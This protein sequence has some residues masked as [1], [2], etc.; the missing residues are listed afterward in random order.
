ANRLGDPIAS[1]ATRPKIIRRYSGPLHITIALFG[2]GLFAV[3]SAI[4]LC[5]QA[6]TPT[7]T[8]DDIRSLAALPFCSALAFLL[9]LTY[10]SDITYQKTSLTVCERG[11]LGYNES[12]RDVTAIPWDTIE[13]VWCE[14][15]RDYSSDAGANRRRFGW[16]YTFQC[17]DGQRFTFAGHEGAFA[18][19]YVVDR[20]INARLLPDAIAAYDAGRTVSFGAIQVSQEGLQV[21]HKAVPWQ[22]IL[23]VEMEGEQ[24]IARLPDWQHW[25]G[26]SKA[27]TPNV[28][29]LKALIQ[30]ISAGE[31]KQVGIDAHATPVFSHKRVLARKQKHPRYK[32]R[33]HTSE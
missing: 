12:T 22:N 32:P 16:R 9:F 10:H 2:F 6:F 27:A 21:G 5:T 3:V 11:L 26:N 4:D 1:Y 15:A 23:S 29:V 8:W 19:R 28:S 14:V 20:E 7:A 17:K 25:V 24:I 13:F 18:L 33:S 31:K 30:H